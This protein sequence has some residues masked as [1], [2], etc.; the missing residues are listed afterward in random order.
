MIGSPEFEVIRR[1]PPKPAPNAMCA[2]AF[3]S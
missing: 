2:A 1:V 3:S